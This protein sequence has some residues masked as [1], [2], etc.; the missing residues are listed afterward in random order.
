M[1]AIKAQ[2]FSVVLMA[3]FAVIGNS[4]SRKEGYA[5]LDETEHDL[6]TNGVSMP[7][8]FPFG[9]NV[10]V[11]GERLSQLT[12]LSGVPH[13]DYP[14]GGVRFASKKEQIPFTDLTS[15]GTRYVYGQPVYQP[16][17]RYNVSQI[18]NN[19][20]S[21]ERINVGPG[22]GIDPT[23][24]A[25][26]GFHSQ[27]RILPQ[28]VGEYKLT[29]LPGRFGTPGHLVSSGSARQKVTQNRP[30]KVWVRERSVL[31]ARGQSQGGRVDAPTKR[32]VFIRES[33][34][35]H[36]SMTASA[37]NMGLAKPIP[38]PTS[39]SDSTDLRN[40]NNRT[41]TFFNF[42]PGV[43]T[44]RGA[45][46]GTQDTTF[47]KDTNR[48]NKSPHVPIGG[49]NNITTSSI[50]G[51][52]KNRISKSSE[53]FGGMGGQ[54]MSQRHI[55]PLKSSLRR[56]SENKGSVNKIVRFESDRNILRRNDLAQ[57]H[58]IAAR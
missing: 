35:T 57:E 22:L 10:N 21:S 53:I 37:Q 5:E 7:D 20:S 18:M 14:V 19:V 2:E 39:A 27:F 3:I 13:K 56:G 9:T 11:P 12:Q 50:G 25:S 24:P 1:I 38:K 36:R 17:S 34:N 45:T 42:Q 28:N 4:L 47:V 33:R 16:K 51:T 6:G 31:G 55:V 49:L 52:T 41:R 43:S 58:V 29:T 26:G 30:Q 40:D 23:V 48:S 15:N 44:F 54:H 32:G 8:L 46:Q